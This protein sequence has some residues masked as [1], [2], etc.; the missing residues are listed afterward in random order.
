ML[1]RVVVSGEGITDM[2]LAMVPKP[3]S[4]AWWYCHAKEVPYQ[5]GGQLET[6]LSGNQDSPDRSPKQLLAAAL[7]IERTNREL[8]CQLVLE[9]ELEQ[10]DMPSFNQFR[11]DVKQAI[12]NICG[13]VTE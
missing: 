3:T 5:N 13:S 4:E 2:G 12:Q 1:T 9:I 6:T 8:L 11:D 10:M 7:K